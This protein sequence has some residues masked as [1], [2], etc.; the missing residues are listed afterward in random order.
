[1]RKYETMFI[2]NP[3]LSED[4]VNANMEKIKGIF[5]KS[6]TQIDKI[7]LLGKKKLAY[8]INK[9]TEGHFVLMNFTSDENFPKELDRNFRIMDTVVIRH[10]IIKEN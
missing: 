6:N 5:A 8:E 1:M 3:D 7:D 2:L 9:K 4:D 10:I